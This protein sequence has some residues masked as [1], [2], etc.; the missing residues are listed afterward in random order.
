[1]ELK[2]YKKIVST[3]NLTSLPPQDLM[4]IAVKYVHLQNLY[5]QLASLSNEIPLLF[6]AKWLSSF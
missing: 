4:V 2:L 5:D 6:F 1:M 3:T